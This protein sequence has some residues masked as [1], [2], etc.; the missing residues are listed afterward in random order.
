MRSQIP[1]SASFC[2]FCG[3]KILAISIF[4]VTFHKQA[5]SL[6]GCWRGPSPA[7]G[8]VRGVNRHARFAP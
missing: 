4:C 8:G 6:K 7:P 3:Q 2:V 5:C 1:L